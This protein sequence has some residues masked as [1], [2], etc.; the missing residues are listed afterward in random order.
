MP[1]APDVE[2]A[3]RWEGGAGEQLLRAEELEDAVTLGQA[4]A[5]GPS[6]S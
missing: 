5:L 4:V 3:R 2:D 1:G 6:S